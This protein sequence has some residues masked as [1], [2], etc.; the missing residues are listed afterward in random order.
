MQQASVVEMIINKLPDIAKEVLAPLNNISS[1]TMY[2]D[3][4][5]DLIANN[6]QKIDKILKIAEDSLGIDLKSVVSGYALEKL[7]SNK[8]G[9]KNDN[10]TCD[11]N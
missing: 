4:S 9:D 7:I 5:T 3:Q 2:G 6:T 1:I 8:K 11:K 10:S